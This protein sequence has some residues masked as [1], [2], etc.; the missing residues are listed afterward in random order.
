MDLMT[1]VFARK[2]QATNAL[3]SIYETYSWN[4][5]LYSNY[6]GSKHEM[7]YLFVEVGMDM[8]NQYQ[9]KVLKNRPVFLKSI[10]NEIMTLESSH[11]CEYV[12]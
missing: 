5:T 1:T 6:Q 12:F 9:Q 4:E 3:F 2:T 11:F 8:E 10:M 7:M